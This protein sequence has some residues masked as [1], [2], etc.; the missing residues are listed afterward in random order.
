M[1]YG[2]AVFLCSASVVI[3]SVRSSGS[4]EE[5]SSET[6]ELESFIRPGDP[7]S[8]EEEDQ[9]LFLRLHRSESY[10]T[11]VTTGWHLWLR[12]GARCCWGQLRPSQ[13]TSL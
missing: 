1:N 4:L 6:E 9:K 2:G 12:G 13:T 8:D 11:R 3:T 5:G 10:M 7:H